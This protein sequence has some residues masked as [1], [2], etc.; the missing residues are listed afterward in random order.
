MAEACSGGDAV[1]QVLKAAGV[2]VVFGVASIHNLPIYDAIARRGDL[3]AVAARSEAGAANMADGYARASG[4][5]GV[6]ITS[7]GTGAGNACGALVEAATAGSPVLHLTG[8]IA[9]PHLDQGKGFIHEARDQLGMLRAVSKQAHRPTS[10]ATIAPTLVAAIE[11][12]LAAPRGPVSVELPIDYQQARVAV[13]GLAVRPPERR[14]PAEEEVQRAAEVL[15]GARRPLLWAGGGAIAS[16]AGAEVQELAE[17]LGAGVLT[18]NAGRGALPEDHPLCLGN[19]A[20][21]PALEPLLA[22]ADALLAVGTHFRANETRGWRLPLP[23]RLVQV[24]VDPLAIGRS[25]PAAAGLVGD[26]K[27]ALRALLEALP[28]ATRPDPAYAEQLAAARAAARAALRATLGPYARI[29]DELRAALPRDAVLVR[30]VTISTSTWG[31]RLFEL[32]EPRTSIHAA[33][34]GIGQGFQMALGAKLARPERAVVAVCGDGGFLVNAGELATAVQEGIAVVLLLFND[35]GYGV[36]RNIQDRGYGGRRIGVD[37]RAPD[38]VRLAEAFGAWARRVRAVE[39]F[40][41]VLHAALQAGGPALVEL[42][43]AAI[44]PFATLF[45]GPVGSV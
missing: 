43:M 33:G 45:G 18:S 40:A 11:Q 44:G 30:D 26:A 27:L 17:R 4:R 25:E 29:V 20:Q 36:L 31:N 22:A 6:A 37:L 39:Q 15:A 9:S 34:G 1:V 10:P 19:F 23:A 24:D 8:Q 21:S 3:R 5:L 12:A 32:Y 35:G 38:F 14:A 2:E 41:P 42:D 16:E 13:P 7:T 28:R